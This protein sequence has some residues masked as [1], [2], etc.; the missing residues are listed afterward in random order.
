MRIPEKEIQQLF[1]K[2]G[3]A[4]LQLTIPSALAMNAK[5]NILHSDSA[6]QKASYNEVVR[7]I[8]YCLKYPPT[9]DDTLALYLWG[10]ALLDL[11]RPEEAIE[12]YRK[13]INIDSKNANAYN[14][15]GVTLQE[16]KHPEEPAKQYNKACT[17][18]P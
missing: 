15:W 17:S 1:E 6:A 8:E 16:L 7:L 18:T 2:G 11:K 5:V 4:L 10:N 3:A 14:N 13:A 9:S 12:Q